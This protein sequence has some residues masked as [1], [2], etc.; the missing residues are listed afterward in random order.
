MNDPI[1][2][3]ANKHLDRQGN[4][5]TPVPAALGAPP[6]RPVQMH[7]EPYD[8]PYRE[9]YDAPYREPR[10]RMTG[11]AAEPAGTPVLRHVLRWSV[12]PALLVSGA[13]HL[14]RDLTVPPAAAPAGLLPLL[15]TVL[16]LGVGALLAVRDTTTVW[17][18]GAATAVGVVALHVLGG[19]VDFD[20]LAGAVGGSQAWAG[21]LAVLCA[22]VGAVLAGLALRSRQEDSA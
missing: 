4:P 13:L 19:A 20:P 9:L 22:A 10:G 6:T 18:A 16:C 1:T 15:A 8:P 17:R 21:V 11:P 2:L 12:V 5:D 3:A 14:P 7:E